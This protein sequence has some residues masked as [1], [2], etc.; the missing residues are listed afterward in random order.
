MNNE[1]TTNMMQKFWEQLGP[2]DDDEDTRSSTF[3]L[4]E[5]SLKMA[6]ESGDTTKSYLTLS[7]QPISFSFKIEDKR[8]GMHRF[9]CGG[10]ME[11]VQ[12]L[13]VLPSFYDYTCECRHSKFDRS[14]YLY[15]SKSW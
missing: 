1:A 14:H 12:Q 2:A 13:L 9:I 11:Q 3:N 7:V 4:S 8:G 15:T 6:S 10:R 5:G